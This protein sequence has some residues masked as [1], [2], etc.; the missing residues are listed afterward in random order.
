MK[1]LKVYGDSK[2]VVKQ[3]QNKVHCISPHLKAY[4]NEVWGLLINFHTFNIYSIPREKNAVAD[5]LATLVARLVPTNNR[6]LIE[7]FFRSSVPD[8]ITNMR[9]FHDDQQILECLMNYDAF[10]GAIID[11]K[12]DQTELQNKNFIPRGVKNLE[13][14]FDLDNK[15][16]KPVNVKSHSLYL[17]FEL[18][19]IGTEAK[20]KYVNLGKC[21]SHGERSKFISLFRQYKDVF[22]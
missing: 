20:P 3:I 7:L 11:D 8:N 5:L 12:E 16:K 6:C 19:N 9:V 15:F 1:N 4:K 14:M 13:Q 22:S 17:Q 21:C 10:K 18:I 2:I